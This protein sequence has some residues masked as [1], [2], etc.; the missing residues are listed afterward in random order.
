MGELAADIEQGAKA[1]VGNSN[2][3]QHKHIINLY[4][5]AIANY[6]QGKQV[7]GLKIFQDAMAADGVVGQKIVKSLA[8]AGSINYQI[9]AQLIEQGALLV[10]TE[11]PEPL[12]EEYFLIREMTKNKSLLRSVSALL[13]YQRRKDKL[14][15]AR[16]TYIIKRITDNLQDGETGVCFLGAEHQIVAHLPEDIE[17]VA[18]KDP[19]KV[20]AYA[21]K[22]R[23]KKGTEEIQKL[24]SYLIAPIEIGGKDGNEDV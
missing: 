20:R 1:L 13:Q 10:K 7:A 22:F 17:V 11:D 6:W 15:K 8:E 23:S 5:Q 19:E 14:L 24:S 16:D 9:L 18:L 12:K 4:W 21:K 3:Q 2:M